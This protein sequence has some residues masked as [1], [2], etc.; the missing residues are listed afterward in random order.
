MVG[1]AADPAGGLRLGATP[2]RDGAGH[3]LG[4]VWVFHDAI[5]DQQLMAHLQAVRHAQELRIREVYHRINNHFQVLASLLDLHADSIEDPHALAALEDSQQRLQAMA[6]VHQSL[7]HS[8]N[9]DWL[10]GAAYVHSLATALGRVY[11]AEA[12]QVTL[13]ITADAVW[14]RAETA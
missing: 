6:L 14:V 9:L 8:R 1:N 10:D 7:S 13:T 3:L 5:A 12:R 4:V 2:M 11:A